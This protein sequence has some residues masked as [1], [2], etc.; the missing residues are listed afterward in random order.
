MPGTVLG[1]PQA[2]L[3]WLR[4]AT[5]LVQGGIQ[6][7][8]EGIR[9]SAGKCPGWGH[10]EGGSDPGFHPS[11]QSKSFPKSSGEP[12]ER[13]EQGGD[14]VNSILDGC[15]DGCAENRREGEETGDAKIGRNHGCRS[16]GRWQRRW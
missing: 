5:G 4:Q 3:S 1:F 15:S 2:K 6:P 11:S 14:I 13:F 7:H 16:Q 8:S 12:W 10:C 9:G